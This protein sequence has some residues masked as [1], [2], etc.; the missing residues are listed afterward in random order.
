[1]TRAE[2]KDLEKTLTK[3]DDCDLGEWD[4]DFVDDMARRV[5]KYEEKTVISP[6][7]WEQLERIKGQHL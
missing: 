3:L 2:L 6:R 7:Q 4:R 5:M 1:M